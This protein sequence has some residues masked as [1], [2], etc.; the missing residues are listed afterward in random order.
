MIANH[1]VPLKLKIAGPSHANS[2]IGSGSVLTVDSGS[3]RLEHNCEMCGNWEEERTKQQT[4]RHAP[5][6]LM[7]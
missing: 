7:Y 2:L 5:L 6:K 4:E 3:M 1:C